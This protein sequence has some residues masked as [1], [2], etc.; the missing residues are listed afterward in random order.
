[1]NPLDSSMEITGRNFIGDRLSGLGDE[2]YQTF[3]PLQ[4]IENKTLF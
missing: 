1:M 4:N 2:R 3:D